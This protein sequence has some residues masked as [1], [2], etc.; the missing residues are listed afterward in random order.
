MVVYHIVYYYSRVSGIKQYCFLLL[1]L[2]YFIYFITFIYCRFWIE[3]AKVL[4]DKTHV[5]VRR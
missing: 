1:Y 2:F 4:C 3:R 5:E